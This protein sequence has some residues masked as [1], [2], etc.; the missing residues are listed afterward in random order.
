MVHTLPDY[1]SKWKMDKISANT[2]NAELAARLGSIVTFDRRGNVMYCD[3]CSES[4]GKWSTGT[5]GAGASITLSNERPYVDDA[6]IK[7]VGGS[8][9]T[10]RAYIIKRLPQPHST[11]IGV[12]YLFHI[13]SEVNTIEILFAMEAMTKGYRGQIKLDIA[14]NKIYYTESTAEAWTELADYTFNDSANL[15]HSVKLVMDYDTGKYVRLVLSHHQYDLSTYALFSIAVGGN[16]IC[17]T[18]FR[19]DSTAANNGILYVGGFIFT[20]NEP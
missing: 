10:R 6:S 20:A 16:P 18:R 9:L 4:L 11:R 14:N 7:M 12:E 19:L 8:T 3:R 15:F 17:E 2:D 13:S 1:T 5:T